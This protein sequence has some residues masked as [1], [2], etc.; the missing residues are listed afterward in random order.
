MLKKYAPPA[1]AALCV[2]A[3][4]I[5]VYAPGLS[6]PF[7]FDDITNIVHI[8]QLRI[9][10]LSLSAVLEA[11]T[12]VP[13]GPLGRPIAYASF[14]LNYYFTGLAPYYFKVTN[15]VIHLAAGL[16]IFYLATLLR[17]RLIHEA[18]A[19]RSGTAG[20]FGLVVFAIWM[21]HPLNLT[22]V[23][24]VV[25]R[26][27]S[28]GSL[29]TVLGLIGY[30]LGR[31]QTLKGKRSGFLIIGFATAVFGAL[32]TFTKENGVLL[33]AYALVV[34]VCFYR[35]QAAPGL[36]RLTKRALIPLFAIPFVVALTLV[37]AKFET[38]AGPTAYA[39]RP[40]NLSERLLT[41]TRALWFY[42]RLIVVPDTMML[43]L[44]HDDFAISKSI[45][46]PATTAPAVAG[47]AFAVATAIYAIKAAPVFAFGVL[48]YLLGHSIESTALPLELV[49]EHRN[50]LPSVGIVFAGVH[51][52]LHPRLNAFIK[53]IGRY[54]FVT[55]YI[56]LLATATFSRSSHWATEWDLYN[57][58]VQN[59]PNSAR[60]HTMMGILYHDMKLYPAADFEF[61]RSADLNPT[62]AD[63]VIRLVHH[64]FIARGS[65]DEEALTELERRLIALP[66]NS[67]TLWVIDPLIKVTAKDRALHQRLLDMY[68]RTL[69]RPD[70]NIAPQRLAAAAAV[71]ADAYRSHHRLNSA[72]RL[73]EFATTL[74]ARASYR[75]SLAEVEFA[76]RRQQP[77]QRWLKSVDEAA[78]SE[79]ERTRL[80][81]LRGSMRDK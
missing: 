21:L 65:A 74:D 26:M 4:A 50:Y 44:Y 70:I 67:V 68:A 37:F 60:A 25:Q 34:E 58:E 33:L 64:Q 71:V 54:A 12:S 49:H 11:A 7:V 81:E 61:R 22:S 46:H 75:L 9:E 55:L 47:L 28:L 40:F 48:W 63:P 62:S 56:S 6:G 72:A 15:L 51:Y 45:F 41:E 2:I 39:S 19:P 10:K 53:P 73:Y 5:G 32:S 76:R 69:M 14:A 31:E 80:N 27:T 16:A 66:F 42:L 29:F 52:L 79:H 17:N 59:H 36:E 78:L 38:I 35:L 57:K 8:P 13:Q 43:G 3:A 1:I 23:L 24:Y 30:V 18:L 20:W 77:A